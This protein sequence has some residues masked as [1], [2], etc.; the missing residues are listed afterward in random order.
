MKKMIRKAII[1]FCKSDFMS[2]SVVMIKNIK[3]RKKK[4]GIAIFKERKNLF[5]LSL[6]SEYSIKHPDEQHL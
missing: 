6:I 1:L 4:N 5:S 2:I 3:R